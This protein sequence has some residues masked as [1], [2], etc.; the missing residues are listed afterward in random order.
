M[1]TWLMFGQ[2]RLASIIP[3]QKDAPI[4][5]QSQHENERITIKKI[6]KDHAKVFD[7]ILDLKEIIMDAR[8]KRLKLK[9]QYE[10]L[11]D[12]IKMS[13]KQALASVL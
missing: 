5:G 12:K 4:T 10:S 2:C 9:Q 7:G 6:S 8:D 11:D 3:P 13:M 1:Y